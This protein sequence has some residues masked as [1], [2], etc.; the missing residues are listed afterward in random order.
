MKKYRKHIASA[1]GVECNVFDVLRKEF[2]APENMFCANCPAGCDFKNTHLYGCYEA[3]RWDNK[4]IYYCPCGYIFIA[5]PIIDERGVLNSGIITGP[6]MMGEAEDF[7]D[8]PEIPNFTTGRVNDI[9]E[10]ISALF[11]PE[12]AKKAKVP[13]TEDFLNTIYKELELLPKDKNYPMRLEKELQEAIVRRDGKS[14]RE[15]L[16]KLLGQIFFYSNGDF[17]VIK[18]RAM[19]LVVLLSRSAIDGGANA[20]QIFN[21]N[22]TI[23]QEAEAFEN[24]EKLS[25]WLSGAVN[26]FMSYMFEFNDIKHAD[27]IYKVTAYIKNNYMKKLSL[28]EIADYVFLSKTY[29]SKI[30]NR[31]MNMTLSAYINKVRV[32]KSKILLRDS[33]MSIA[34]VAVLVGYEDQSYFTKMFKSITGISPGVYKEKYSKI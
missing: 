27:T 4:Y 5:V 11:V 32:E 31:E 17:A 24:I 1:F 7:E 12:G 3:V 25:I 28:D 29:L 21:L 15:L 9:T 6:I 22:G 8:A 14:A 20:Q 18:A 16:N 34:E 19:E 23:L 33:S 2:D 10:I 26:R 13:S 30:F